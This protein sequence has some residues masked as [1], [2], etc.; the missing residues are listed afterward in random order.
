ML[1]YEY[2]SYKRPMDKLQDSTLGVDGII[3]MKNR[4]LMLSMKD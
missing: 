2:N 1:A 4:Y 3:F